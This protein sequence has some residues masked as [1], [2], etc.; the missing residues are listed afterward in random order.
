MVIQLTGLRGGP[1]NKRYGFAHMAK[2]TSKLPK[3]LNARILL[4]TDCTR[5]LHMVLGCHETDF[6]NSKMSDGHSNLV[7]ACV[8]L[9]DAVVLWES[10]LCGCRPLIDHPV[11]ECQIACPPSLKFCHSLSTWC[12]LRVCFGLLGVIHYT[13]LSSI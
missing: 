5:L 11:A 10:T 12:A 4:G 6:L 13:Y 2:V 9:S 7:C 1:A 3:K 8:C